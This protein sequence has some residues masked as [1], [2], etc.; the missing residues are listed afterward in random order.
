M[1]QILCFGDSITYGSLDFEGSGWYGELRRHMDGL[2]SANPEFYALTY[3]LGVPGEATDGL[4]ERFALETEARFS[5]R[6][7]EEAVFIF[8]FGANDACVIPSTGKF[9][10]EK[11]Q[12]IKNLRTVV[13][14]ARNFGGA[15]LFL[16]ITP[17]IDRITE[18]QL[19][20]DKSRKN[21]YVNEY[22]QALADFCAESQAPLIDISSLF[23][24]DEDE[25]ISA[26]GLHPTTKGHRV[27]ADAV[28][29]AVTKALAASAA[30]SQSRS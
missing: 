25:L 3:N 2:R 29:P 10:V 11:E 23:I 18:N 6:Q 28:I 9:R 13:E 14:Q 24:G 4:L 30:P 22:N 15:I 19:D 20:K 12:Y 21:A 7:K 16:N 5:L 8:Q 1:P 27:I 17:V 26:D